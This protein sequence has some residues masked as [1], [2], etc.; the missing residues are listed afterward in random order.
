MLYNK[1]GTKV[2]YWNNIKKIEYQFNYKTFFK[3]ETTKL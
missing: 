1:K 2:T 3:K